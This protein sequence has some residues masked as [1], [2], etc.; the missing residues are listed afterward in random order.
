[1]VAPTCRAL[2]LWCLEKL[3][4]VGGAAVRPDVAP[5]LGPH[6]SQT[7]MYLIFPSSRGRTHCGVVWPLSGLLEHCQACG[8][9]SMG[10]GQGCIRQGGSTRCTGVGGV[11]LASFASGDPLQEGPC[12]TGREAGPSE[13]WIHRSTALGICP[14]QASLVTGTG[15]LWDFGWWMGEGDGACQLLCSLLS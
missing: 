1:M 13:A 15:S 10:S 5:P 3:V 6:H 9:A 11:G 14:V 12:S 2:P 7:G 4:L 8:A